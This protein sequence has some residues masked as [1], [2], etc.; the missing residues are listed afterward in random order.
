MSTNTPSVLYVNGFGSSP[1]IAAATLAPTVRPWRIA[2]WQVG[3]DAMPGRAEL[4]PAATSV[5]EKAIADIEAALAEGGAEAI[6][7][8]GPV[9]AN[10]GA[11]AGYPTVETQ[12][13]Y[14]ARQPVDLA[15]M[16]RPYSEAKLLSYA[17]DYE[18]DAKVRVP[19]TDLNPSLGTPAC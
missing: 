11:A 10:I 4:Y 14:V 19:P 18:Q 6:V 17:Y 5:R 15:F 8:P 3:G 12:L 7:A 13:G 2:C 9:H 16:G 1:A